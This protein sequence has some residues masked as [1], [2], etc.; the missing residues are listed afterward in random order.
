MKLK[1]R[2]LCLLLVICLLGSVTVFAADENTALD[3]FTAGMTQ[4]TTNLDGRAFYLILNRNSVG[5]TDQIG[6]SDYGNK[7]REV[8]LRTG[9]LTALANSTTVLDSAASTKWLFE[10]AGTAG[11]Y[12]IKSLG[13][14]NPGMYLKFNY[15]GIALGNEA[16]PTK[17]YG[18]TETVTV[19]SETKYLALY[20][21]VQI[22]SNGTPYTL[23]QYGGVNGT[24]IYNGFTGYGAKNVKDDEGQLFLMK[25][26]H[27]EAASDI[28][29]ITNNLN[30]GV[31]ISLFNYDKTINDGKTF[32][33]HH[34]DTSY[35][36]KMS[37]KP[38]NGA[39]FD[40][41]HEAGSI[42]MAELSPVLHPDGYP[43]ATNITGGLGYLFDTNSDYHQAT[44]TD[45]GGLFQLIDGYYVYDSVKNAAYF[46]G[47][48]F[49]LYD[50]IV[51]S[52]SYTQSYYLD[53]NQ[54]E[55]EAKETVAAGKG[56]E[57]IADD[58]QSGNFLPFNQL[59]SSTAFNE[60]TK[61]SNGS[62]R[63]SLRPDEKA[64]MWFGMTT[65]FD[66]YMPE[67]GKK[68]GENMVFRFTGDDDVWVY[69][70]D[71]LILDIGGT[72]G[73]YD[74]SIDF[75]TGVV[76]YYNAS[77][78][79][80]LGITTNLKALYE[81]AYNSLTDRNSATA[82]KIKNIIDN[83]FVATESGGYRFKDFT[84]H[85][86]DFFYL[87]RGGNISY[88]QLK[89]NMDPLPRSNVSIQKDVTGVNDVLSDN[90]TYDFAVTA[91]HNTPAEIG[92]I[93]YD[94]TDL[95]TAKVVSS[96][97]LQKESDGTYGTISLTDNQVASFEL[98][99][100]TTIKFQEVVETDVTSNM[101]WKLNG[102]M[103][104]VNQ[105]K[106]HVGTTD[107]SAAFVCENT[108]ITKNLTVKK[109]VN[110]DQYA[111]ADN[112]E[113]EF[114]VKIDGKLYTG[115]ATKSTG[116]VVTLTNGRIT[117]K[118][119][120]S[121]T[122]TGIPTD[123]RYDVQEVDPAD[124]DA[125]VY[126][127]PVYK[128]N[129]ETKD[130]ASGQF[131]QTDIEVEITNTLRLLY[132]NLEITKSGIQKIDHNGNAENQSTIFNISGTSDSGVNINMD[133]TIVGNDSVTIINLPVG[134]YTV[135]EKTD[136]S[137]RYTPDAESKDVDIESAK[138]AN[139]GFENTRTNKF[140]L[141]GDNFIK[142]L[143]DGTK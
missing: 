143:F 32:I 13:P 35:T 38:S 44:M 12:Y 113:F 64:D 9:S 25:E 69:V 1:T 41:E 77:A 17:V 78:E 45:G 58:I 125:Y 48:R 100:G 29:T 27:Y 132:G 72:H 92:K 111:A 83:G 115:N 54:V 104:D 3:T 96:G 136:W 14:T 122:I 135:K 91:E 128:I 57:L 53:I 2:L 90:K 87:E 31:T 107:A 15:S 70:D 114:V 76:K 81:N 22:D 101:T 66:F 21:F 51:I 74:G 10:S 110:G 4:V 124:R 86:F 93:G 68:N 102:T 52:P 141:S 5:M 62:A 30:I 60:G 126:E 71:V 8:L 59:T 19:E 20:G 105:V 82:K 40:G 39:T 65:S 67:A 95:V 42:K 98:P 7:D 140:W 120:E 85:S 119:N 75:A 112:D 130:S 50:D 117:M 28:K 131:G 46:N 137:W 88:C 23:N 56:I 89:F 43:D 123:M 73:A 16:V 129:G 47:N 106:F 94:I 63:Y 79:G 37:Q 142:N 84:K 26:A 24:T 80:K 103:I 138:T 99:Q 34:S 6:T 49:V 127:G 139:V 61:Q 116:D 55:T 108:R 11:E 36:K 133:V 109:V 134:H 33:F 97:E 18:Y 121:F 118:K